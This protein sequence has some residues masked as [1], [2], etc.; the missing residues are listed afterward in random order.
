MSE[1]SLP[2]IQNSNPA[3]SNTGYTDFS[4]KKDDEHSNSAVQRQAKTDSTS[5]DSTYKLKQ[6]PCK[7]TVLL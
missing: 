4:N 7:F 5:D 6:R 3:E 1:D 2:N